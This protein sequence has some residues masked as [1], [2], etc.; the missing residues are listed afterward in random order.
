M[1]KRIW[2]MAL[3]VGLFGAA[4]TL[5]LSAQQGGGGGG[6]GGGRPRMTMAEMQAA[7][8]T[9]I[10]D[11]L[12]ATD[13][14]WKALSPKVEKVQTLQMQNMMGRFGGGRGGRGGPGGAAPAVDPA[15]PANPVRDASTELQTTLD[16]K[17]STAEQIKVKLTALRDA[18]AKA[19]ADLKKAQD[20]LRELVTVRQEAVLVTQ[21]LLD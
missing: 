16:N 15:A 6:G 17:E 8:L 7:R 10:K 19:A 1:N 20:E 9:R 13:D 2:A 3:A 4:T 18:K 14:E 21:G 5:P 12:G 11:A